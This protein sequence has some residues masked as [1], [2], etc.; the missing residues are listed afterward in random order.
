MIMKKRVLC[1]LTAAVLALVP[2]AAPADPCLHSDPVDYVARG[3]VEPQPG[4]PGYSGDL[5]CP[6]CGAVMVPGGI[7]VV[8][9][10]A[11]QEDGRPPDL[12]PSDAGKAE[13]EA[14]QPAPDD[15]AEAPAEPKTPAEMPGCRDGGG[16]HAARKVFQ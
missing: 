13:E 8:E 1:F 14:V 9:E 16:R 3:Y 11:G 7:L 2:W 5:V 12:T 6:Y 4:Q 15:P 10:S